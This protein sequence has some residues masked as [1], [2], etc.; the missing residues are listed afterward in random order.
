[1]QHE[2]KIVKWNDARGFGFAE[3]PLFGDHIFFHIKDFARR[4]RRPVVG[5]AILLSV[6]HDDKGRMRAATISFADEPLQVDEPGNAIEIIFVAIVASAFISLLLWD[7]LS[8]EL[9]VWIL[10][11]YILMTPISFFLY[12]FDKEAARQGGWRVSEQTLLLADLAGGWI[13]GVFAQ[14]VLRHKISKVS[15]LVP[16]W[17]IVGGHFLLCLLA[18]ARQLNALFTGGE[19]SL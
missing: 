1:V 2:G 17:A 15:F 7:V 16:F 13:G 14:V 8:G 18:R 19:P 12:C 11:V 10:V 9:P 6:G 4:N 3:C 5:D